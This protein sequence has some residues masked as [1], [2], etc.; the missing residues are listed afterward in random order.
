MADTRTLMGRVRRRVHDHETTSDDYP[1]YSDEIYTDSLDRA[2]SRVNLD[3]QTA[4]SLATLPVKYEYLVEIRG[5]LEMCYIR[6][7]EGASR[8]VDAL[9]DPPSAML[10]LPSGYTHQQQQM[11]LDGPKYWLRLAEMLDREY[12]DSIEAAFNSA[13][14]DAISVVYSTRIR[15]RTGRRGPYW[16][17][18]P[19]TAPALT[20]SVAAGVVTVGWDAVYSPDF[21]RYSLERAPDV[22]FTSITVVLLDSDNHTTSHSETPVAGTY[23]YRLKLTNTN[24]INSYS[25]TGTAIVA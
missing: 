23:Y 21:S 9:P 20:L 13:D 8:D 10:V 16:L 15:S 25:E 17:D 12:K 24:D 2:L 19:I 22:D 14:A 11:P 18:K 4:Y 5:A 7:G 3:L 1:I 6:G